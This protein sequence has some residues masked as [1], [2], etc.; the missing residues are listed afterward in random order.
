MEKEIEFLGSILHNKEKRILAILG[1]SK[2][3]DKIP[4]IENLVDITKDIIIA[5]GMSFPFLQELYSHQ[6]G[7]TKVHLPADPSKLR[8]IMDKAHK[9]GTKIHFPVDGVCSHTLS[10]I[11]ATTT[12]ST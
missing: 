9:A 2:V 11:E 6:L 3:A 10:N 1:G 8:N 12:R 5:G 4:L 7:S